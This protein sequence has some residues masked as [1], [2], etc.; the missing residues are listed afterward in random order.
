MAVRG[1]RVAAAGRE[2][3]GRVIGDWMVPVSRVAGAAGVSWHTAHQGFVEIAEAAGIVVTGPGDGDTVGPDSN[4]ANDAADAAVGP[5][6]SPRS[7][8]GRSVSG[9]MPLVGVLGLDD[10]RRGRPRYHRDPDTGGWVDDADRWASVFVD[11]GGGHGLLGQVESRTATAT[12]D[13]IRA[14]PT[15]WRDNVWAVTIDMSPV[16]KAA[17]RAALPHA[18]LAVDP[19]HLVHLANKTIGDVRRRVTHA[20]Y[21]RRGRADDPEYKIRNLLVRAEESLSPAVA[22]CCARWP[23]SMTPAVS[24][25]PPGAPRNTYATSCVCLPA[26]PA[27]RPAAAP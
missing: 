15:G 18:L 24:S 2:T 13:W 8:S 26:T 1:G 6:A 4:D 16:Y 12:A 5:V 20:R 14:Q 7:R 21:G 19:F 22:G 25:P 9:P 3:I 17:A 27:A 10:H 23:I 11:S